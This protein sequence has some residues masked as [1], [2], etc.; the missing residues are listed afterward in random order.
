MKEEIMSYQEALDYVYSHVDYSMSRSFRYSPEKFD[1]DRMRKFAGLLGHP[2]HN[3][4]CIHV[5]GTKGKGSI[6]A[7]MANVLKKAGYK[8]GLYTSPHL[9]DYCE[10][11]QVNNQA[12][13]HE[14]FVDLVEEIKPFVEQVEKLSTF[15]LTTA[16]AFL[17]FARQNV[18]VAVIEVGLGGR[19]DATNIIDPLVSVITSISMDHMAVLGDTIEKIAVEKGGIIKS[20]RPLVVS[21]QKSEVME[22]FNQIAHEKQTPVYQ[23]GKDFWYRPLEHTLEK[24]T[25]SAGK[26]SLNGD[27]GITFTIPLLGQHQVENATTALAA[28]QIAN[29]YGLSI[30][31]EAIQQ[32]F[33]DVFWPG[34][35]EVLGHHP[36]VIV[37]SAHNRD[38]ALR[39][40]E[41]L[42]D[43]LPGKTVLLVFGASEDKDVAGMFDELAPDVCKVIATQSI[44]PRAMETEIIAQI[45]HN[46]NL[47]VEKINMIE[48]ALQKALEDAKLND[49]AVLVTGS[50]FVVAAVREVWKN[51]GLPLRTY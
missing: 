36:L 31:N 45:A 40:K 19:L 25:F 47:P 11:I 14:G 17:Y 8:T 44:H 7:L 10:R 12:I 32:G 6:S 9:E 22:I 35:F 3:F 49:T 13:S 16:L 37:D 34:R 42:D 15:E 26:S 4:K 27:G 20:G 24:Q 1:L 38:S 39:L 29:Q 18:D 33:S 30:S 21:P 5:A 23:T 43:Y 28:L 46:H 41:T 48:D 50:L 51:F 2:E